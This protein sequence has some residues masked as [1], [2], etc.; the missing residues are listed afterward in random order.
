M[1]QNNM[2]SK[3]IKDILINTFKKTAEKSIQDA[4]YDK[5][6][7]ATVQYCLDATIGQYKIK[8]QNGYYNAYSQDTSVTYINNAQVYVLVPHNDMNNRMFIT[9]LATNDNKQKVY[10]SSMEGDQQYYN[11]GSNYITGVIN[12]KNLDISTYDAEN[13]EWKRTIWAADGTNNYITVR[14]DVNDLLREAKSIRIGTKIKTNIATERQFKGDYGLL[15]TFRYKN[16][17]GVYYKTFVLDTWHMSGT[18]FN[19]TSPMPQYLHFDLP[20]EHKKEFVRLENIKEF[21]SNFPVHSGSAPADKYDI[22][23]LDLS[24]HKAV[25]LYNNNNDKYKLAIISEDNFNFDNKQTIKCTAELRVDGNP[26]SP[27]QKVDYYWAKEDASVDNVN[28]PKYNPHTGKGWYCLTAGNTNLYQGESIESL[29]Q[30]GYQV[31]QEDMTVPSQNNDWAGSKSPDINIS[32]DLFVGKTIRIKCVAY[33]N[34]MDITSEVKEV[35]NPDGYY[36]ILNSENELESSNGNGNFTLTAAV[37]KDEREAAPVSYSLGGQNF[38][39]IYKWVEIEDQVEKTLPS[40]IPEDILISQPEWNSEYDNPRKTDLEV[41]AYL[42]EHAGFSVCRQRYYYY[43]DEYNRLNELS[44]RTAQEDIELQRAKTRLDAIIPNKLAM[45]DKKYAENET[46]EKYY[47]FGPSQTVGQYDAEMG[48]EDYRSASIKNTTKYFYGTTEYTQYQDK[49]NTLYLLPANKIH[50]T[51]QYKVTALKVEQSGGNT[52]YKAIGTQT[53]EL[54]NSEK[55]TSRYELEIVNGTRTYLYSVGG[56][57]PDVSVD[58][59][60]FKLYDNE[61]DHALLYDSSLVDNAPE[62]SATNLTALAPKWTFYKNNVGLTRT[63]YSLSTVGYKSKNDIQAELKNASRFYYN[64]VDT[65]DTNKRDLNNI[66]LQ[67]TLGKEVVTGSTN[68]LFL[69]QGDLNTNGTDLVL[70]IYNSNYDEYKSGTLTRYFLN[71]GGIH[72][73]HLDHTYLYA[74]MCYDGNGNQQADVQSCNYVNLKFIQGSNNSAGF[75]GTNQITLSGKWYQNGRENF[76]QDGTWSIETPYSGNNLHGEKWYN[77]PD[78]LVNTLGS[79][80]NAQVMLENDEMS[81]KPTKIGNITL[82]AIHYDYKLSNNLV[83]LSASADTVQGKDN[84]SIKRKAFGY[85]QMPYFYFNYTGDEPMPSD[86]NPAEHIII[87]GGFDTVQYDSA[88]QNPV[89]NTQTPFSFTFF[90]ENGNNITNEIINNVGTTGHNV[91]IRWT[92]SD[93][94][95]NTNPIKRNDIPNIKTYAQLDN[96]TPLYGTYC[97]YDSKYYHCD[98]NYTKSQTIEIKGAD[99]TVQHTYQPGEFVYEYWTEVNIMSE[100]LRKCY[101][102]PASTYETSAKADLF[103]SWVSLFVQ[104]KKNENLT[105]QAEVLIPI[106]VYCNQYGSDEINNWDGKKTTVDD[107]YVI[108]SKVAAGVKT[109]DNKFRG[110]T[111]GQTFYPENVDRKEEIGLFG[112]GLTHKNAAGAWDT[113]S[114]ARTMY[115]DSDT[116][117]AVFGPSGAT[118]I[119]LDPR[120]PQRA[121]EEIWSKLAGWYI[122]PNYFYKGVTSNAEQVQD[123]EYYSQGGDITPPKSNSGSNFLGSVGM[124]CPTQGEIHDYDVWLWADNGG[125]IDYSSSNY[126]KRQGNF[127]VTYGGNLYAKAAVID[128][129]ITARGGSFRKGA[130]AID[131]CVN[132]DGNDYLLWNRNFKVRILQEDTSKVDVYVNGTIMAKSGQIGNVRDTT[133]GYDPSV[134]FIEYSWYPWHLPADNEPWNNETMYLDTTQGMTKKYALYNKY[135][136]VDNTGDALFNGKLYTKHG[137]IGEWVIDNN[138]IH[139]YD[140]SVILR[141]SRLTVGAFQADA[142]GNLSGP[143]WHINADGSSSFD[144]PANTFTGRSFTTAGGTVMGEG[145]LRLGT[146]EKFYIGADDNT[147][148]TANY[149]GFTFNGLVRFSNPVTLTSSLEFQSGGAAAMSFS[150]SG[151]RFGSTGMNISNTGIATLTQLFIGQTQYGFQSDGTVNANSIIVGGVSLENYIKTIVNSNY[152]MSCIGNS[153]RGSFGYPNDSWESVRGTTQAVSILPNS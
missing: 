132:K 78:F 108:S 107:A 114:W 99:G 124:Y 1:A 68:F 45:I 103:N 37:F 51:I 34:N 129:D 118:Q 30:G 8:Y 150:S 5:T 71:K 27:L 95:Y 38:D 61:N 54:H 57:K 79:S 126:A 62:N 33:Y 102:R 125:N 14:N 3:Q 60:Y 73:K 143:M 144:N 133:D 82:D 113:N 121:N 117:R 39:V 56:E 80:S 23:I 19:F 148:M 141:P 72:D 97:Q 75:I 17:K 66:T 146:G 127:A 90:D 40:T 47:I 151:I 25:K 7:L 35:I 120:V 11:E 2:S 46:N 112:Y 135:F 149:N 101:L 22:H 20:A 106:N 44:E 142:Q 137:R 87:S 29:S 18:P 83:K 58:S 77:K 88:G 94:F 128:G 131:I 138:S 24:L 122:S 134:L 81:Y 115:L 152:I 139:S 48:T 93:G 32:K 31:D 9:G 89:Y 42:A 96:Q 74:T 15:F 136:Y 36:L 140:G 13:K 65:F 85:Y 76:V 119:I 43:N 105:Y 50:N 147:F 21:A 41:E 49:Q 104:Y 6:I 59:L 16:D 55:A 86:C 28:H 130:A 12:G 26:V 100:A 145:G 123:F 98:V 111:I 10:V 153:F 69:K 84:T 4:D 63:N 64:I 92:Y 52:Y 67:V 116:G 53:I 109:D 110:I 70:N 91:V